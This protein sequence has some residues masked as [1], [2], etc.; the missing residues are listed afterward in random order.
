M[1]I[2]FTAFYIYNALISCWLTRKPKSSILQIKLKKNSTLHPNPRV[3]DRHLLKKSSNGALGTPQLMPL[4]S[5]S[6][7]VNPAFK[8]SLTMEFSKSNYNSFNAAI[9]LFTRNP[10]WLSL[11][12]IVTIH[13]HTSLFTQFYSYNFFRAVWHNPHLSPSRRA[14]VRFGLSYQNNLLNI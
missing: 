7:L 8:L 3:W 13:Y 10:F 11:T 6:R 1:R 14:Q 4:K 2:P 9:V 12:R 5:Y